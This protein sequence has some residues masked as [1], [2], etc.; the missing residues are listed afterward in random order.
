MRVL[1]VLIFLL[2]SS[3]GTAQMVASVHTATFREDD[4]SYVELYT[5]IPA[6]AVTFKEDEAGQLQ[7]KVEMVC[8][9]KK[10]AKIISAEKYLLNSPR[11]LKKKDFWDVQ[12]Y[13][14]DKGR[15]TIDIELT[16]VHDTLQTFSFAKELVI[17][18]PKE[19][20]EIS[21]I[22]LCSEIGKENDLALSKYGFGYEKLP[23][24]L[25]A[26]DQD[27]VSFFCEIYGLNYLDVEEM[28]IHYQ[29]FKGFDDNIETEMILQGFEKKK[30]SNEKLVFV[31]SIDLEN[32]LSG[33]YH[34]R[35]DIIDREKNI[36]GS[37]NQNF[38]IH[39]PE[40]DL[41][42]QAYQN[43]YFES[44]FVHDLDIEKLDYSLRAI[45]PQIPI[46]AQNILMDLIRNGSIVA[47]RYFLFSYFS[48]QSAEHPEKVYEQYMEVARA[49]DKTY[50]DNVGFGFESDRGFIFLKYGRPNDK[51]VITDEPSAPP[52]E[53][54]IYENI[55]LT[56]Q[57]N[58]KFLFYNPTLAGNNFQLLHSTCR[59]EKNNPS[60][61]L[62]LYGDAQGEMPHN[63][64]DD[65]NV[66][67]NYFRNARQYFTEF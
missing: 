4:K 32:V 24:D 62:D 57:T 48:G 37:K 27:H 26:K 58:V 1:S 25:C 11:A 21:D 47:K 56:K 59:G 15:Y 50:R 35:V 44:S 9:I 29:L 28:V 3:I 61:E 20:I 5:G 36:L 14:L 53:I 23:Y 63:R 65:K 66:G 2:I 54:W 49:V 31:E 43:E 45:G 41:I 67:D 42:N 30:R 17:D 46:N 38:Q 6:Q 12:R 13:S 64:I 18:E 33:E 55:E 7:A 40:T 34:L 39:H 8:L 60:W 19:K 52:Y 22:I 16:D 10:D 51:V